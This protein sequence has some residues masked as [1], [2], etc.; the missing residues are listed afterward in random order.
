MP[1][2]ILRL[3]ATTALAAYTLIVL[4]GW[5]AFAQTDDGVSA[6]EP[7]PVARVV[8]AL[9]AGDAGALLTEAGERVEIV[10]F[11]RGGLFSRGQAE[12]VLGGFFRRHPAERVVLA[13][14]SLT[15]EE[16]A[17][18]GRYFTRAG[19]PPLRVYV[20]FRPNGDDW[21]LD[22]VRIER[23]TMLTSSGGAP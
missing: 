20:R 12:L 5:V 4:S 17:A 3:L 9:E 6:E 21:S 14:Q 2:E 15:D 19:E 18:M 22:A 8:A 10:L 7:G 16:R 23:A 13:E 1:R 11:E